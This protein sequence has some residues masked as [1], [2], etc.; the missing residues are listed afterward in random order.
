MA[1]LVTIS[2]L[3]QQRILRRWI[4]SIWSSACLGST[5]TRVNIRNCLIFIR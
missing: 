4:T 1:L 3:D 5:A 2:P